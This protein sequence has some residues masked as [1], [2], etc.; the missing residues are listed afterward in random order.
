MVS[1]DFQPFSIVDDVGFQNVI[2]LLD[3]RY[4]LPS[5]KTL[6]DVLLIRQYEESKIKLLAIFEEVSYFSL[7][8]D[9]WTSRSNEGY[10]T[11]TSHFIDTDL[12]MRC[13]VLS[14]NLMKGNHTAN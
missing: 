3:P 6:T 4:D 10:L 9:L 13:A 5:R 7:T 1:K 11:V 8:C 14:T 2:Q 12:N